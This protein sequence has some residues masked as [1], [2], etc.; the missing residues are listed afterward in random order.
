MPRVPTYEPQARAT[1]LPTPRVQG[2]APD[3]KVTP[4]PGDYLL[5]KTQKLV[6][7]AGKL[8]MQEKKKADD[9]A[10]LELDSEASAWATKYLYDPKTGALNRQGKDSFGLMDEFG[11]AWRMKSE[12]WDRRASNNEQRIALAKIKASRR[13]DVESQ[14]MRHISVEGREYD[15]QVTTASIVNERDAVIS[16]FMDPERREKGIAD[17]HS[18][19]RGYAERTG[20]GGVKDENGVVI[21]SAWTKQKITEETSRVHLGVIAKA[22]ATPGMGLW[23]KRYLEENHQQISGDDAD[24]AAKMVKE[25]TQR[26]EAFSLAD[27]A[28]SRFAKDRKGGMA[29][30]KKQTEGMDAETRQDAEQRFHYLVQS[31]EQARKEQQDNF[32]NGLSDKIKKARAQAG[33]KAIDLRTVVSSSEWAMAEPEAQKTLERIANG[34]PHDN[35]AWMEFLDLSLPQLTRLSRADFESRY[36]SRFGEEYQRRAEERWWQ[37]ATSTDKDL[38]VTSTLTFDDRVR[39]ALVEANIITAN[40]K[41]ADLSAEQ[42][43]QYA[44]FEDAAAKAVLYF[45]I[46]ELGGKRKATTEEMKAEIGKL[47]TEKIYTN[48]GWFTDSKIPLAAASRKQKASAY[49]EYKD[50][51]EDFRKEIEARITATARNL[52]KDQIKEKVQAAYGAWLVGDKARYEKIIKER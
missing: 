29:Y 31:D 48:D 2:D 46:N 1:Q 39:N 38:K 47:L 28:M 34:V 20:Q 49:Q 4:G 35:Q 52:G 11:E 12:E 27:E 26:E 33:G 21:D 37:A 45:E 13:R 18:K 16:Q 14:L 41:R 10:S 22:T 8:Y 19:I 30:I 32:T 51:P 24:N 15:K 40:K 50:I 43:E 7:T 42:Q 23:A 9:L 25:A 6:D 36:W 3:V 17:I 5:D 44:A